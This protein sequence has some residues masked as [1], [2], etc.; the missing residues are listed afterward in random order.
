MGEKEE[1]QIQQ[2]AL[3]FVKGV[4]PV[5]AKSLI[6]YCGGIA[7]VFSTTKEKLLRIP[8][9]GPITANEILK[10][11]CFDRAHQEWEAMHKKGI[12]LLFYL[13][14]KYPYRLKECH[15]APIL[16]YKKSREV[17][18]HP[19]I[20]AVVGTRKITPYGRKVCQEILTAA[21]DLNIVIVSGLAYGVDHLAHK[22]AVDHKIPTLAVVA[23]GLDRIYPSAH[24]PLAEKMLEMGGWISEFPMGSE[25]DRENFPKRN[26][27]IAGMSD[28]TLVIETAS[29]GGSMITAL[30]A[31]AYNRQVL[32]VPG[33]VGDKA[34]AGCNFLI[35]QDIAALVEKIED[36]SWQLG[37]DKK[38]AKKSMQRSLP[39]HL[40][41]EEMAVADLFKGSDEIDLALLH[42]SLK[43]HPGKLAG[44]LLR[45]EMKN[46]LEPIPGNRIRWL[47]A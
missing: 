33:R 44:L 35:R 24:I 20:L 42:A 45:M 2:I 13:D 8:G 5:L 29:R 41:T 31:E 36:V 19:R 4:G 1:D 18:N 22:T 6:S 38:E 34:S 11:N 39:L 12:E 17:L 40:T 46:L 10:K 14:K 3:S 28:A 43:V 21:K 9:L 16:L 32:A 23:H 7:N 30:C 15:D 27:I 37:W 26:R 47:G 25:P